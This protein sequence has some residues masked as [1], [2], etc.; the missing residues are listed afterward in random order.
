VAANDFLTPQ[1]IARTAIGALRMDLVLPRLVSRD[2]EADFQG[3]QGTVI[4]VRLP[5]TVT[6][7]GARTY[8]QTL[9]DAAT[10]ITLD[11]ITETTIP[12]T[13]GPIL[14][15]GVPVTDEDFTFELSNFN[16]QVLNPLTQVV[17]EGAEAVLAGE[18]NSFT[19]SATIIPAADGSDIHAA[20]L[21]AR[22]TLNK[23]NVPMTGRVLAVSPEIEMLLLQ[24]P[25]NR[26]VRY[27][28][29][30]SSE[31]LRNATIGRLYGMDVVTAND[32]TPLSLIIFVREAFTFVMR[33]PA[34]P[35]GATFGKSVAYQGLALR[36]LR[37]YD[38]AFLQDRAIVSTF[39][40]AETLD[41]QRA[42]RLVAA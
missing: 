35:A 4:N 2:A 39:A 3:G 8:T 18:M 29:S 26:L 15:K 6:G 36:F 40:G 41:A 19:A 37:D 42:I 34:V 23:R 10:P 24:D 28:A 32:L 13:I 1:V 30:G 16:E 33:A 25:E 7:G 12:V 38:S 14:Y 31:A 21:E 11:R 20:I 17:G 22:M 27:D 5:A 9:R